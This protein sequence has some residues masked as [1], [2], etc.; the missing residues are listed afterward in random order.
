[1]NR[2]HDESLQGEDG[3][4][5]RPSGELAKDVSPG[6]ERAYDQT[7]ASYHSIDDF[8]AKLL[9]FLPIA[10]SGGLFLVVQATESSSSGVLVAAGVF[11]FVVTL[12]LLAYEIFGI[13]RCHYLI[14]FGR[15]LE[16]DMH[17]QHGQFQRRP[18]E[19]VPTIGRWKLPIGIDEPLATAFIYP[20]VLAGWVFVVIQVDSP[21]WAAIGAFTVF[22][23]GFV[24]IVQ[25]DSRLR[26]EA[27]GWRRDVGANAP[28][29]S[30]PSLR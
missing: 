23:A 5:A 12:G 22:L 14:E 1:M 27:L 4:T 15:R 8:R 30:E 16:L 25:W 19:V 24:L 20:A 11:G 21:I 17:L 13:K 3:S 10:S 26:R 7:C 6:T 28:P 2:P 29:R 18:R 9:G